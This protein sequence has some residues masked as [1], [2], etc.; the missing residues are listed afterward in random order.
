MSKEIDTCPLWVFTNKDTITLCVAGNDFCDIES[1]GTFWLCGRYKRLLEIFREVLDV[2]K[3]NDK[4]EH[5][6]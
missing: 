4:T 6:H 1:A 5:S 2:N 3:T